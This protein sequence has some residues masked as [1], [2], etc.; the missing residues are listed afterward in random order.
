MPSADDLERQGAEH[1]VPSDTLLAEYSALR[2]EVER[3]ANVQWNV[4]ALQITSAGAI[5]GLAISNAVDLAL[6]L[7][8]PLSSFMLGSRYILH[9]FHIKLIHK[10]IRDS[11]SPRLSGGLEWERWKQKALSDGDKKKRRWFEVT[12]WNVFHPTRLAFEGVAALALVGAASY[13]GYAWQTIPSRG[14]LRLGFVLLWTLG[15]SAT[16]FLH[17]SFEQSGSKCPKR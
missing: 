1:H 17:R 7:V 14:A 6:L 9:D 3:R 4:F 11:L 15:A 10:Y 12:D 8:V 2:A 16:Y 5:S 13:G